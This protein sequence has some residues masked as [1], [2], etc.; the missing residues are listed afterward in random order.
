MPTEYCDSC[1]NRIT[2][3]D[4]GRSVFDYR[5]PISRLIQRFKYDGQ[6]YL[7]DMFADYLSKAYFKNYFAADFIC[8]V[9]MTAKSERKRGY[10][11][12][13]LLSEKV[14]VLTGVP[15]IHC[16]AKVK[17]TKRQ[18]RLTRTERIHNLDGAFRIVDK[19]AV[20]GKK[21]LLIDD[22]TTTGATAEAICSALKGAGV[23]QVYMLTVASVSITEN[24]GKG[25][26][27][28]ARKLFDK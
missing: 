1:K 12:G 24:Y 6:R 17:E 28:T 25:V 7:V 3:L 11:H 20:V 16:I 19:K 21:A 5:P 15:V 14:G 13:K 4:K 2:H 8:Y 18:A 23:A 10:N 9:P 26:E 27:K 22:V